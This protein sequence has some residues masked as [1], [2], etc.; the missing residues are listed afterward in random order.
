MAYQKVC[1]EVTAKFSKEGGVKPLSLVW[2]DGRVFRIDRVKAVEHAAA[3]V[4]ALLPVRYTC[5][6]GGRERWLYLEPEQMR[7]FVE[8][9]RPD[10][11]SRPGG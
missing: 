1:V 5:S 9:E 4:S 6:I 8:T 2:E 10:A 11:P 3:R 7:W